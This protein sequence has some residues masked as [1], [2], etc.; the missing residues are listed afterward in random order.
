MTDD[1]AMPE[2]LWP[3]KMPPLAEIA[4]WISAAMPGQPAVGE[5]VQKIGGAYGGFVARLT[6]LSPSEEGSVVFKT[7]PLPQFRASARLAALL[8]RHCPG[9]VPRV[10]T[11]REL[12][13]RADTAFRWFEGETVASTGSLDALCEM[14]RTLA[15]VQTQMAKVPAEEM[16]GLP[17]L[18]LETIPA[19]LDG[20]MVNIAE[21]YWTRFEAEDDA[22][23][24][25]FGI[26]RD[27]LAHLSRFRPQLDAWAAELEAG[28]WPESVDH[29]DCLPHNAVV[30][31]N[32]RVLIYDWEQAVFGCPF[33]SLDVLLAFAQDY[34][35]NFA[36]GLEVRSERETD[37]TIALRRA[38][39]DALPWKTRAERERAFDLALCLS[40]LRYAWAEGQLARHFR[41]EDWWAEDMAWWIMRAL[42][43]WERMLA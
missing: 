7:N 9:D 13:D 15:R 27:L 29:V 22:L 40:P 30:Q 34:P 17:R 25:R 1:I 38:Y 12:P 41:Q 10:L 21:R 8:S 36:D 18:P 42:R 4:G 39:L 35:Q 28:E 14:A 5:P 32:G 11:W 19:L 3:Q 20:L 31:P 2:S 16:S 33:F 37:G 24:K 23:I 6:V 26:P 43:R